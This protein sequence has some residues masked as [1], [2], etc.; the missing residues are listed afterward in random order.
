M[1][2][3]LVPG[4]LG[5]NHVLERDLDLF[6]NAAKV[7]AQPTLFIEPGHLQSPQSISELG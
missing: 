1:F 2:K 7:A 4:S 3:C 5:P 6:P